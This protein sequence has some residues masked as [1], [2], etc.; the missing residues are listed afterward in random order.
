MCA[1]RC[2]RITQLQILSLQTTGVQ[3]IRLPPTCAYC[4]YVPPRLDSTLG[5]RIGPPILLPSGATPL[6][7]G[8]GCASTKLLGNSML[9]DLTRCSFDIDSTSKIQETIHNNRIQS[10]H[11][12]WPY[13]TMDGSSN[14]TEFL[15][16]PK[17]SLDW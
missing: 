10:H 13:C 15:L 17:S 9:T 4:A 12:V 3:N 7:R 6:W 2:T 5:S 11:S 16:D 14:V 8:C 1:H